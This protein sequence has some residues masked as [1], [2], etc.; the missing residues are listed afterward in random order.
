MSV[1]FS[2][3]KKNNTILYNSFTNTGR[4]PYTQLY[5]GSNNDG[6]SS[7]GFSR[8][9]FDL[10]LTDLIDKYTATTITT[11]CTTTSPIRH[12]L[13]MTNT[14][15]FDESLLNSETSDGR[16]RATSFDLFLFR[17]PKTSGNTGTYQL[18][19]EGV[20][21]DYYDVKKTINSNNS[22]LTPVM[23]PDNKSFSQRP[24]NWFHTTTISGWSQSGIYSNTNTGTVNYSGLTIVGTQ[25]FQFG[26]ENIEID[27]TNEINSILNGTLTGTTGWGIAFLP[28]LET[29]SGLTSNYS[30]GFFTRHTQT[31]YEP[32]LETI[33]DDYIND[34]RNNF[35]QYK[36]NKLYLYSYINGE[37][38]NLDSSPI[39]SLLDSNNN[40]VNFG[41]GV[42]ELSTCLKTKGIY[43]V[44]IPPLSGSAPC[45]FYDVWRPINYNGVQLPEIVNSVIMYPYEVFFELG[46]KSKSPSIYGFD[47]YGLKQDEKITNNDLRKVGV[48]I[49]KAYS[50]QEILN[51]VSSYY[52]VYVREGTTEVDVQDWTKIS[53]SSNEY[54]FFFDTRDKIPNEY[55]IDLKVLSSGEVNTYKQQIK[56]QIVNQK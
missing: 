56:F 43:E 19:D 39:F 46:F 21:S 12:I 30:V 5:F 8:V 29:M 33:Y 1:H 54:F 41:N 50:T 11:A 51:D 35:S 3:F 2:Y 37:L 40:F 22:L 6:I 36:E 20:G 15:S 42:T 49:K 48:S 4:A 28:D 26:N 38:T 17:L 55:F 32:K 13:K 24:S 52:R 25:H 47:F 31:F 53:K 27:M 34:N 18:W 9:I 7:P 16:L 23:L 14:S 10:D 44:V 45:T